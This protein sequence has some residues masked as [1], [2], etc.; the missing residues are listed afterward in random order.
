MKMLLYIS[1][2]LSNIF[3][4]V[5]QSTRLGYLSVLALTMAYK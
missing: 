3:L 1:L 2:N 5:T 4:Q